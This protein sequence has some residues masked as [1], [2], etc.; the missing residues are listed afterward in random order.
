VLVFAG[1][2]IP[3]AVAGFITGAGATRIAG[4]KRIYLLAGASG[5]LATL[6]VHAGRFLPDVAG[7]VLVALLAV[8]PCLI[9][10]WFG[11]QIGVIGGDEDR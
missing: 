1:A 5:A 11:A 6:A 10:A 9:A 8:P 7:L 2:L 3:A 4:G